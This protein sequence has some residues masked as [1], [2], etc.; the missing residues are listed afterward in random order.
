MD[1]PAEFA[2]FAEELAEVARGETL[3]RWAQ[4]C[5]VED[6]GG[7]AF[8]PVTDADRE[9]ERVMRSLIRRRYPDH[10]VTGEEF[11]DQP[12]TGPH[13]WSL[14]PVDGTRSFIC[15]LPTW[16]TLIGLLRDDQPILGVV[17]APCLNETY[18]GFGDEAWLRWNGERTRIRT[19]G[20][21]SLSDARL[22]ATDPFLFGGASA[23]TF[24]QLRQAAR[25]TR[26]GHD[27]YGYARLAGGSIDLVVECDLK[28][29]DYNALI[30][31]VRAAGGAIGDWR[32][33]EDFGG[34]RL[35]AAATR[36][37]YE[38]AVRYFDAVA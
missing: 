13:C 1:G 36:E 31:L 26:Y 2:A 30:P 6:K 37:L 20:C 38:E 33:G 35:I 18:I 28:S 17:D 16:V 3:R 21:T 5:P 4:S 23:E 15:R 24:D 19:S 14:D 8:D 29:H 27:G 12:G 7:S 11:P 9:A 22:S 32:G 10:G 25:T 34:G